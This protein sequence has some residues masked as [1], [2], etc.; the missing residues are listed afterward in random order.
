MTQLIFLSE[1]AVHITFGQPAASG[2]HCGW[3]PM[4]GCDFRLLVLFVHAQYLN[5]NGDIPEGQWKKTPKNME[6]WLSPFW[7]YGCDMATVD[8][9]VRNIYNK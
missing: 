9:V 1:W 5:R 7:R 2:Y 3:A 4:L 8:K 6:I